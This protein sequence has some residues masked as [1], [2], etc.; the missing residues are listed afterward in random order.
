MKTWF[1]TGAGSG[2]GRCIAEAALN[3]GDQAV[4]SDIRMEV[5][6]D[7]AEHFGE[8]ALVRHLDVTDRE[9]A[10]E[11]FRAGIESCGGID[12]LVNNAGYVMF[13]PVEEI[14]PE[15]AYRIMETNFFGTFCLS[16]LA[17]RHMRERRRGTIVQITSLSAV[18]A[19]AGNGIY[20]ATKWAVEGLSVC[21]A[22]EM[23]HFGVRVV[24]IEPGKIRTGIEKRAQVAASG[25]YEDILK[26]DMNRWR[27]KDDSDSD[28]DPRKCAELIVRLADA[29]NLPRRLALT[30]FAYT[31]AQAENR[32]RFDEAEVWRDWS[33]QADYSG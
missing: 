17:A 7:Y 32:R 20:A 1:I 18:D 24:C 6:E 16:R 10:E 30:T 4:V 11:V 23:R 5:M 29:E 27:E 22:D 28:G 8:R 21:L 13:G 33:V 14:D 12:V 3:R 25:A 15:Q 9:E 26:E 19:P 2:L 31:I